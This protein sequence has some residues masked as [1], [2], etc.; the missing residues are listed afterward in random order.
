MQTMS[1]VRY[2]I[3]GIGSMGAV[4]AKKLHAG[5]DKNAV[6]TAVSDIAPERLA[7]AAEK[8]K[9]VAAY[10]DYH[11][12]IASADVDVVVVATPHYEHP[13]IGIEALRA[14]KHLLIEKPAG[15][16]TAQVRA[17]NEVAA[18]YPAQRFGIMY[19]QRTNPIYSHVKQ[20]I[21][22][23]ALG[24]I[25]RINWIIT[26]WYRP[27]AYY[28]QGGWRG[29]WAGEGGGV[30]IN[31][32]PHQLDLFQWFAGMPQKVRGFAKEGV[33]RRINVENDVT[34]YTEYENGASGVFVT[35]TRDFPGT[36]RLEIDADGGRIVIESSLIRTKMTYNKL[37]TTESEFNRTTKK[38]M[39]MIPMQKIRKTYGIP[40]Q[41]YDL[42]ID[43][44]HMAIFRNFS[45]AVLHDEPLIAPGVEGIRGLMLSNAV[46]LSSW[47]G[48]EVSL[49]ID[50]ALFKAEL[51]KKIA[52][53]KE[54]G[55]KA[56]QL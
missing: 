37:K 13:V 3:I 47:L 22:S 32:A 1:K 9:G 15:V 42:A 34:F 38:R 7:W 14:G 4:H 54:R 53:E 2:G 52:T 27:Q 35:T 44:Q 28:D 18:Q 21:D 6:L 11:D 41:P 48:K 49:P 23:G 56:A 8:L 12:L 31:Q 45:R 36:N 46:H 10:A 33:E 25:K 51:D 20:L 19:N 43:G 24:S 17:L 16:Y 29:T 5:R 55:G 30:L 40:K 50:E 26:D 39:P